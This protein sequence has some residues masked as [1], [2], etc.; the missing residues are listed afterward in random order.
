MAKRPNDY[1]F[2]ASTMSFGEHL[3]ELRTTLVRAIIGL[4]IGFGIGLA[5]ANQI[6]GVIQKPLKTSLTAYYEDKAK[7]DL[8][9]E[10]R[11]KEQDTPPE[12]LQ[13]IEEHGLVPEFIRIEPIGIIESL[14]IGDPERFSDLH[15]HE[16]RYFASDLK[17]PTTNG[18]DGVVPFGRAF[19]QATS[20]NPAAK[21]MWDALTPEQQER[22]RQLGSSAEIDEQG[23]KDT[24]EIL[25]AL[26]S[27]PKLHESDAFGEIEIQSRRQFNVWSPAT[28]TMADPSVEPRRGDGPSRTPS[29]GPWRASPLGPG[30][31]PPWDPGGVLHWAWAPPLGPPGPL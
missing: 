9:E 25:N 4:M 18:E 20:E 1:L 21:L 6:V 11:S 17:Q 5:F 23:I 27:N 15:Y 30:G 28:W 3:E 12:M 24:V 29:L 22:L 14:R 10:Y 2:E 31:S 13:M 16:H 26:A 8:I 7:E 19:E